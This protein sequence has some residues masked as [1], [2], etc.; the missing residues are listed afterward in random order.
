MK[1]VMIGNNEKGNNNVITGNNNVI[2]SNVIM[3]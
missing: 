1:F 2:M 3:V